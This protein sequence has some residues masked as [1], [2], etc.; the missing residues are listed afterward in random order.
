MV[1]EFQ[2][3]RLV[4]TWFRDFL[5]PPHCWSRL[6]DFH[7]PCYRTRGWNATRFAANRPGTCKHV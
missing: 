2:E 1:T 5:A 7:S 6:H 3:C 4:S